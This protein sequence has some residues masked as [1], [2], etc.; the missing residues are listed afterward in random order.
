[1][2]IFAQNQFIP[3][4]PREVGQRCGSPFSPTAMI[5]PLYCSHVLIN[6]GNRQLE[7]GRICVIGSSFSKSFSFFISQIATVCWDQF[8]EFLVVL[9]QFVE[10][11]LCVKGS[12]RLCFSVLK[13]HNCSLTVAINE[14]K[15][16]S[17]LIFAEIKNKN[18]LLTANNSA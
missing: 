15:T 11:Q 2:P 7:Q 17:H 1:M 12:F 14:N 13:S 6:L 16:A 5:R 4:Y 8:Y 10:C 18:A 3:P 9:S